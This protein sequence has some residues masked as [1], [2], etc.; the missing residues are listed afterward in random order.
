VRVPLDA[1]FGRMYPVWMSGL[2]EA[3]A[4]MPDRGVFVPVNVTG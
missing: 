2:L 4:W 1:A 3:L